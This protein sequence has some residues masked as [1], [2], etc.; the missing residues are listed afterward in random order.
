MLKVEQVFRELLFLAEKG[1]R[2]FT[3]KELSVQLGISLTNVNHALKPLKK[4]HAIKINPRNFE[5]INPKKV[6]LHWA[7]ARNI[8]KDIKLSLFAG[9]S[10]LEIEK[11]MPNN[12]YFT[13][14]SAFKFRFKNA[15]ADYSSV[16][17][18]SE[19]FEEIKKRFPEKKTSNPP[20]LFVLSADQNMKR[21][22]Q[23]ATNANIFV[24]LW[25]LPQW[26]AKDFLNALEEKMHGLL[27]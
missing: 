21:Y 13:A 26:F 19:N 17:V 15:P 10:V 6:L 5:L 14:F 4:M 7:S 25:N 24:D 1:Q 16:Y 9:E 22:G 11:S 2:T 23:I 27:E 18:Y 12:T 3:Q 20:N 8:E